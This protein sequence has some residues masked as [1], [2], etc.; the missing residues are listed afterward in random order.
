VRGIQETIKTYDQRRREML[1]V[2]ESR[3]WYEVCKTLKKY[4]DNVMKINEGY[5]SDRTRQLYI[6]TYNNL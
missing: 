6:E 3:S 1:A 2:R 4:Y 5:T